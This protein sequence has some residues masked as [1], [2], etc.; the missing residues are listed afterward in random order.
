M[1]QLTNIRHAYPEHAGFH[2]IRPHGHEDYTFL[3]FFNCMKFVIDG[4]ELSVPAG[5]F[6]IYTPGTP[7]EFISELPLVHNWAHFKGDISDIMSEV[8]LECDKLYYPSSSSFVTDIIQE[9]EME[10]FSQKESSLKLINLKFEELLIKL[11]RSISTTEEI[12]FAENIRD[13]FRSLRE[14]LFA[15]LNEDWSVKHMAALTGYSPS[16][17]NAIYKSIYGITPTADLINARINRAKNL[18]ILEDMNVEEISVA[19]GY[20]NLTHFIRQF[21]SKVG[22]SPSKFRKTN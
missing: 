19:L 16:R 8:N 7:Q 20:Q 5:S 10:F 17:F 11:G 15:S 14:T 1:I 18:L 13:K 12:E 2:M 21:K 22:C 3:H 6:I 4:E 9:M